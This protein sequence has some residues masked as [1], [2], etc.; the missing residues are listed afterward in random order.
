MTEFEITING[1]K[2]TI[3]AKHIVGGNYLVRKLKT[4]NFAQVKYIETL[5][6]D[7]NQRMYRIKSFYPSSKYA[8]DTTIDC[9]VNLIKFEIE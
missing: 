6:G 8:D 2:E 3:H 7:G 9:Q 4:C 1:N 5:F